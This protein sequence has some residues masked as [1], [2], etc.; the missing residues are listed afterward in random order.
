MKRYDKQFKEEAVRLAH[1][2]GTRRAAE[3]GDILPTLSSWRR[4]RQEY[5]STPLLAV[6]A[7]TAP[8][9]G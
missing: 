8:Q 4:S 9:R 6:G 1:E 3:T 5:G 2:I 7:P